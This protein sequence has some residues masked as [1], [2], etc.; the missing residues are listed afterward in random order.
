MRVKNFCKAIILTAL[1]SL[2]ISCTTTA[3]VTY[4]N[5][6]VL[7]PDP[8][9]EDGTQIVNYNEETDTVS[10]PLW[11]WKSIV[12]YIIFISPNTEETK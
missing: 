7:P 8:I 11:Y 3:T 5:E 4:K 2:L 1:I 9:A 10:M 12:N 6:Y